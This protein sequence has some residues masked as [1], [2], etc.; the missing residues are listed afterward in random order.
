MKCIVGI[1][2]TAHT[3]GVGILNMKG[4]IL[5]N[6]RDSYTTSEGGMIREVK[7]LGDASLVGRFAGG[8]LRWWDASLVGTWAV[9]FFGVRYV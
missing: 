4:E 3:F 2:S 7:L 6:V 9:G 1:E 8:T 5:A